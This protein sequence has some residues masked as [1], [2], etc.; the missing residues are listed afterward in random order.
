LGPLT[1]LRKTRRKR[2][3]IPSVARCRD[4]KPDRASEPTNPTNTDRIPLTSLW[5]FKKQRKQNRL[6]ERRT[7]QRQQELSV[8]MTDLSPLLRQTQEKCRKSSVLSHLIGQALIRYIPSR[9]RHSLS[10]SV[11]LL[12]NLLNL[13][14]R[15]TEQGS[16]VWS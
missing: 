14:C 8:P 2:R 7:D 6:A 4:R 15:N 9:Q 1:P 13:Y 12:Q 5:S 16:M 11:R 10:R 3:P